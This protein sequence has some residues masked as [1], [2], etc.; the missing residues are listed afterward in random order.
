MSL[1]M[2]FFMLSFNLIMPELNG[3]IELLGGE[4]I[5]GLTIT[6]F[7]ISAAISRPFSGKIS[8]LVGRKATIYL[9]IIVCILVSF[10]YSFVHSVFIFL[11]LRFLHGLSAGFTPTGA[12]ALITDVLPENSRGRAMAIWGTFISLGIG[13]GQFLGSFIYIN[14]NYTVLF[15][16]SA[17]LGFISLLLSI[18][19][20]ET[21]QV[22][23][24]FVPRMLLIKWNDVFEPSV[25]PA[26][27]V[28]F[29]TAASSGIIFVITPDISQFLGIQNKGWFFGIYVISTILVRL[30]TG[31]LS[32]KIGRR[33]TLLIGNLFLMVSMVSIGLANS[34]SMYTFAAIIFGFATGISSPTLFAWTADLSSFDRRGVGAGTMFIAL[35]FGIML[36]SLSTLVLYDSKI[37][38][39]FVSFL[40]GAFLSFI[41][42]MYLLWHIR[43]RKSL[44]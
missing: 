36:G 31:S 29:L 8:D 12:T 28:M 14:F 9:G 21:L 19:V 42:S 39:V 34:I 38:S 16:T 44:F 3:F 27:F 15:V 25:L 5:K 2:F 10:S 43:N 40:F 23:N 24:K 7:T 30:F 17:F 41:A 11:M 22:K 20:K 18:Y 33:K 26:S 37:S 13:V 32:D 6:L 35:E 4:D 1:S